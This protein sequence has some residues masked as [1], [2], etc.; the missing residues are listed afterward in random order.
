MQGKFYDLETRVTDNEKKALVFLCII[1]KRFLS[2]SL[3][4]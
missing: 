1:G 4:E 2:N 3:E